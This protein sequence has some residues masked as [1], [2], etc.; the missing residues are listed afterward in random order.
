MCDP[1]LRLGYQDSRA[2]VANWFA[3]TRAVR[4]L[5]STLRVLLVLRAVVDA[6][7]TVQYSTVATTLSFTLFHSKRPCRLSRAVTHIAQIRRVLALKYAD[8]FGTPCM[9]SILVLTR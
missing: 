3:H 8:S 6:Y 1:H 9:P 2:D 7:S 4:V 5:E